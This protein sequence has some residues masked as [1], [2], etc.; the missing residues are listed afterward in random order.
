MKKVIAI[1]WYALMF[2]P[3]LSAQNYQTINR[4]RITYFSNAS[5]K[6]KCVRIDSVKNEKDS[7]F[8]PFKNI[9]PL[10]Y[11]CHTPFGP[12]WIGEKVII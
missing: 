1:L 7:V 8:Y 6:I 5:G 11:M 4:N 2:L 12:S 10:N 9:R 3:F